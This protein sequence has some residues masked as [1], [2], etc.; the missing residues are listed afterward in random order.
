MSEAVPLEELSFEALMQRLASLA[1][2]LAEDN[3]GLETALQRYEAGMA[4][5]AEC[6]RRL[7][8]AEQRVMQI[9]EDAETQ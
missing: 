6:L 8:K 3:D 1:E 7:E 9:K 4:V 2:S 5:A